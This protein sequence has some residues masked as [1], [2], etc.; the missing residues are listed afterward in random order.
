MNAELNKMV[1]ALVNGENDKAKKHLN[2]YFTQTAS[3]MV[4]ADTTDLPA[5]L[6]TTENGK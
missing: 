1:V 3:A 5:P 2:T 6:I 4:N